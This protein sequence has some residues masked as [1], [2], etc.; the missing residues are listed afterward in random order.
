MVFQNQTVYIQ[1]MTDNFT[2]MEW[3]AG[4]RGEKR[5]VGYKV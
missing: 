3:G 1:Y 4:K 2:L 5:K